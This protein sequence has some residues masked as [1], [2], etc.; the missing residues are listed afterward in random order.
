[1][2]AA[3]VDVLVVGSG[4]GGASTALT[5]A[6]AGR[7]VVV[8]EEGERLDRARDYG[9]PGPVAMGRLYRRRGMTPIQGPVPIG[10][11]EGRCVGGST[12][13]NSGFWHRTPPEA[14]LRWQAQFGLA[15]VTPDDLDPHFAWAEDLLGVSRYGAALPPSTALFA[16]GAEAMGW[17]ASEV[18]RTAPGCRSANLCA[19][20]CPTGA[21]QGVG[22]RLIPL[23]E[24][25]GAR[26]LPRTRAT[27]LLRE[28]RRVTG[29][30]AERRRADGSVELVRIDA[31]T[32]ILCCG[33][34]QTPALLRRSGIKRNVGNALRVHPMLKV[35]ARFEEPVRA[36]QSVL[37]LMQVKEFWPEISLGGAYFSRGHAA[38]VLSE[39]WPESRAHLADHERMAAYYV[40]VRG[41]GRGS[42][43]PGL[44][45][46]ES[47]AIRYHLSPEDLGNLSRGLARLST[48]LLAAG[49]RAVYPAVHGL[50]RIER[51]VDAARWLDQDLPKRALALTTVHAFSSCPMGERADR[52]AADSR[53]RVYGL[54]NLY[55]NDASVL[56][57]SPG[58]NPQGTIM[59]LARRNAL[60]LA[61]AA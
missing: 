38:M 24:T 49:A 30:L 50:P 20:G 34:T 7:S 23:A 57:D 2:S 48:L 41:N 5:L 45:S 1:M 14:V 8:L 60:A 36:E 3:A 46:A 53:G 6:E 26:V 18:E 16:R 33:A 54:D 43:R 19:S 51:E 11:V 35:V 47:T 4:A 32:V 55:L 40:G 44:L 59:A 12:E 10:Y 17:S 15:G 28:G 27:L 21:K 42:V 29:V 52:C 61:E 31:R 37:P 56:P 22:T 58:V 13:I 9:A 39:N 25:A